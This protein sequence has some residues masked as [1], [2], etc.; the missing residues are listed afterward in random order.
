MCSPK[1]RNIV[2]KKSINLT[3]NFKILMDSVENYSRQWAER[4]ND[5]EDTLFE[6]VKSVRSLIQIIIKTNLMGL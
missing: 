2:S 3:H 4:G 6:M 1:N 5:A